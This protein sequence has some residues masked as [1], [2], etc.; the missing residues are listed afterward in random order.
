[1]RRGWLALLL[2]LAAGSEARGDTIYAMWIVYPSGAAQLTRFDGETPGLPEYPFPPDP[3]LPPFSIEFDPSTQQLWGFDYFVCQV[4]CP[5]AH[6]PLLI[7]PL[8]GSWSFVHLPGLE[9]GSLLGM[10]ADIDPRT[11]ELRYFGGSSG[12]SSYS[13][14]HLENRADEPLSPPFYVAAVAHKP[15]I[16]GS[17]G[18]ETYVIGRL[19]TQDRGAAGTPWYQLARIGGPGG[20]PP[21]SSGQVTILGPVDVE[22]ERLWFDISANGTAYLATLIP[23]GPTGEENKLFR[24]NLENGTLDAIGEIAPPSESSF[25]SGIAVAPPGLGGGVVEV[26]ALSR[27]GLG[28]FAVTLGAVALRMSQRRRDGA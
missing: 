27:F 18:V 7:D 3:D 16:G 6:D 13:F 9:L 22:A 2:A 12:N 26:P 15:P 8:T 5:P 10:D 1:M 21:A 25:L 11:R 20:D 23:S 19:A 17:L 4:L 24:V 28:L 14:D